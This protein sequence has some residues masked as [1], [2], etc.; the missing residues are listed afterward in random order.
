[1][2]SCIDL[3]TK[4]I[5]KEMMTKSANI[6]L[7]PF[8]IRL[9][10]NM[11]ASGAGGANLKQFLQFLGY[12]DIQN[13]KSNSKTMISLLSSSPKKK[14]PTKTKVVT[15]R[16]EERLKEPLFSSA[17][18]LWVDHG[19]PLIPSFEES[20]KDIYKAQVKNV[21]I[22]LK[23]E[24]VKKEINLW[25]ENETE[26]LIKDL[27]KPNIKLEPP[28]VL[29]NA[30][31][32]KG[33]WE[34]E[35]FHKGSKTRKEEFH[36]LSGETI[37]VPFMFG[38]QDYYFYRSFPDFKVLKL[39]YQSD[40]EQNKQ[41]SMYIFLPHSVNGL[42]DMIEKLNSGKISLMDNS[43]FHHLEMEKLSEVRIPK[44]KFTYDFEAQNFMEEMGLTL[45]FNPSGEDF[46]NMVERDG[47]RLYIS[48]ILHKAC[49]EVN[50]EGTEAAAA[51][52]CLLGCGGAFSLRP[53]ES[54]VADHPFL[55]MIREEKK[56]LVM[57][58]GAVLNPLSAGS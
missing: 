35:I 3:A 5:Q 36:L 57:F 40:Q 11:V 32:F 54:F 1:M 39:P 56:G 52:A 43:F 19:W 37:E 44:W 14:F 25:V 46:T 8:S 9:V 18:A 2:D 50:D 58:T 15:L 6:V 45:P 29:V 27:I 55:F 22:L 20:V 34:N 10:M 7:S 38:I 17:N 4:V 13:L 28:V 33:A 26:G 42:K 23:G 21:D 30:L 31:Y 49:I 47:E 12:K 24:E 16:R 53:P 51:T 41:F 48:T